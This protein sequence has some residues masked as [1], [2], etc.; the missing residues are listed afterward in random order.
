VLPI[1]AR[2][3]QRSWMMKRTMYGWAHPGRRRWWCDAILLD[4]HAQWSL[5]LRTTVRVNC[6]GVFVR[7]SDVPI[8]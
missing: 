1:A 6:C 4:F 8:A 2:L 5:L 7:R 3:H